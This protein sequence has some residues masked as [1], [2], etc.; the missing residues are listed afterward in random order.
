MESCSIVANSTISHYKV[1]ERRW[2]AGWIAS[3]VLLLLVIF[4]GVLAKVRGEALASLGE[5][6]SEIGKLQAEQH[7][8]LENF[9]KAWQNQQ[10]TADALIG[11]GDYYK[12][13]RALVD[14]NVQA[15]KAP[16]GK[17]PWK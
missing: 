7:V 16:D 2:Y 3:G 9:V 6:R 13:R 10:A 4:F 11:Y 14:S 12:E 8:L 1:F 17:N 5:A 15:S